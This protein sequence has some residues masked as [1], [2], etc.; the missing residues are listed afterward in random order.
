M[1]NI[2]FTN[3][4][5]ALHKFIAFFFLL[6]FLIISWGCE[7]NNCSTCSDWDWDDKDKIHGSGNVI[8]EEREMPQFHSINH[9]T[10]GLVKLTYGDSLKVVVTTDDNILEYIK[11]EVV[12]EEL[13]ISIES[14]KS[15]SNFDLTFDITIPELKSLKTSS[16]GN[17]DGQNKFYVDKVDFVLTSAGNISL[18][19]EAEEIYSDLFSAGNLL[20]KGS[21]NLHIANLYSAGNLVAN[22]LSTDTTHITLNS[23]GNAHVNV[24]DYLNATLNSAGSL[25]YTGHPEI[26]SRLTSIGRIYNSN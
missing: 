2:L 17:I 26:V 16:A 15:L 5:T 25:Y 8:A 14:D 6:T 9:A 4:A 20:L 22:S 11:T 10:V 19:L 13:I 1:Y 7:N 23:A 24:S 12:N 18:E 21:A 3:I